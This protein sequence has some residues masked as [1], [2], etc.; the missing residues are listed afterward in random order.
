MERLKYIVN[1]LIVALMVAAVAI[2]RDG[3][4]LGTSAQE[5]VNPQPK[6][7][8]E[9]VMVEE[10][11]ADGTRVIYSESLA[12]DVIGY[13]GRTPIELHSKDGVITEVKLLENN[14]T[15][16]FF[17]E[18]LEAGY[19]DLWDGISLGDVTTHNVDAVSGSTMSSL[20]VIE[21]VKRAAQYGANVAAVEDSLLS[22]L[23]LK[24]FVALAVVLLGAILTLIKVRSKALTVVV[25]ALNV[26]VL[27]FWCGNFLSLTQFVSWAANGI[28]LGAG[29]ATVALLAVAIIMPLLGKK[30]SYCH[31][32]C[33]MGSA[34]ELL[35]K[36]PN[37]KVKLNPQLSKFLN[38][39]RYYI[40]MVLLFIMWI[41]VGF[42]LINYEVFSA[43]I[44]S[45][46]STFVLI[47]GGV[48]IVLSL[49][50]HRPYC[51]FIC[52]TGALLTVSQRTK[53]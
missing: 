43:F 6:E 37:R 2:G 8:V 30:G 7:A 28:N 27:G 17:G 23:A 42:D 39:L 46:A 49:F 22:K 14:E 47:L 15:P 36:V 33:P 48:F 51:K 18:L 9:D 24:D 5:I 45:S 29:I 11:L 25:M 50:I 3:R 26:G 44:I 19:K 16:S 35:A 12:K 1:L 34:Q 13:A 31:I 38:K 10:T 21:N 4:V 32:H 53:E 40:L 20:A 52:P 41:G